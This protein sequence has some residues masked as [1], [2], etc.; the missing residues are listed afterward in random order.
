[1]EIHYYQIY[2]KLD[3]VETFVRGGNFIF[4]QFLASL[5]SLF[6]YFNDQFSYDS[7]YGESVASEAR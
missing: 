1:M 2:C 3:P 7:C 4:R 5:G 6:P